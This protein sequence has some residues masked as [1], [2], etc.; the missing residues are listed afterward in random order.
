MESD[1]MSLVT[2]PLVDSVCRC[3]YDCCTS[4]WRIKEDFD[5]GGW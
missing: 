2:H 3:G 1:I 4:T 5:V